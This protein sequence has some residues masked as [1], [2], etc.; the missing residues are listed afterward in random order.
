MQHRMVVSNRRSGTTFV[1]RGC[2]DTPFY[3]VWK[4]R[5]QISFTP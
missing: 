5:G 1:E 4:S 2:P 3:A